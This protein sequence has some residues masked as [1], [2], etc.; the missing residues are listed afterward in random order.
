VA[1]SENR[2]T[3][4]KTKNAKEKLIKAESDFAL[5]TKYVWATV[6]DGMLVANAGIDESNGAGKLIFL[7]KDSFAAA[8][9]LRHS[10]LKIYKIKNLG[11]LITDSRIAPLR[12]GVLGV[13]LGYAG[14]A[15][16]RD[17]R[18]KPDIFGHK[19][20]F[21]RTNVADSL[22]T[23]G[24]LVMGEGAERYPLAII[25]SA[26]VKYIKKVDKYELRIELKDDMYGPLFKNF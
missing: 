8:D 4:V 10:L 7:P 19:L 12:A 22:A 11:V 26:P 23:V 5:R 1:L 16:I 2:T 20:V 9:K 15:G 25:T 6:K 14:F 3:V 24:T 18:G 13:A 17:Y 21:T